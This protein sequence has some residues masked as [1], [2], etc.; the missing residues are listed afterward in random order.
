MEKEREIV[1]S[2]MAGDKAAFTELY[3]RYYV[4]IYKFACFMLG[5]AQEAEDVVADAVLDI[6]LGLKKLKEPEKFKSWAFAIVANKCR[7]KM[8]TRKEVPLVLEEELEGVLDNKRVYDETLENFVGIM[9]A[10][11]AYA[12]LNTEEK[13]IV[14]NAVFG[15]YDSGEIS[16][17]MKLNR[18]TVRSK[19]SR[20]L[21]KMRRQCNI[22]MEGRL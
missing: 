10:R 22:R 17:I 8:R 14:S 9:D 18:N 6:W 12:A 16:E 7:R 21:E 2:A 20:A 11:N 4:D 15:G 1:K 13:T 5:R 3:A 19:L